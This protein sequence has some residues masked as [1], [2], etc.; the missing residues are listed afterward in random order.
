MSKVKEIIIVSGRSGAGKSTAARA[1]EDMGYFVVDNL[2]PQ[3]LEELLSIANKAPDNIDR[4]AVIVDVRETAF[5]Q[6]LPKI[7]QDIDHRLYPKSL[8]Y[9]DASEKKLIDRYQETKRR[10]PLD[11]G[12]G[13]RCALKKEQELL[14]PIR[15][16]ATKEIVTD[17][18]TSH[19]LRQRIKSLIMVN[20]ELDLDITIMS[21]GFKHGIPL[22]LD[23]CFDVRF[24]KNPY[25]CP[26]LKPK[27]GL[28][29]EVYD[30]VLALPHSKLFLDKIIDMVQF[31]YPLYVLE[32]KSN[33]TIAIGCTGGRHRSIALVE[34]LKSQLSTKINRLRVEHRDLAR[35]T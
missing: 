9:L 15:E 34:A 35:Q 20:K 17:N 2:P 3:L 4:V 25:Y 16:L 7:W 32:G 23:L 28:D 14:I 10:H 11:D 18:L 30:Y 19:E 22:E 33:L 6:L 29:R 5:L 27:S 8:I 31:L 21:F 12:C 26:E 1:L 13:I 24:L